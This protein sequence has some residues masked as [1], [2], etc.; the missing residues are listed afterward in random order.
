VPGALWLLYNRALTGSLTT[1]P[2][3]LWW[4]FD[5]IGFGP[6]IGGPEPGRRGF[7]FAQGLWNL[8]TDLQSLQ[9]HLFGWPFYLALALAAVPFLVGRIERWDVIFAASAFSMAAAYVFY[10]NPG[11]WYGPRYYYVIIPWL[12]L[13]S[14]RGLI[15]LYRL[16]ARRF[17]GDSGRSVAAAAF[18]VLLGAALVAY[19]VGFYIPA[20]LPTY[21]VWN[22]SSARTVQALQSTHLRQGL[23]FVAGPDSV[24]DVAF[25][26][27]SPLLSGRIV[28]ARDEG[29]RDKVLASMYP[30]KPLWRF[31]AERLRPLQGAADP[32]RGRIGGSEHLRR[33][34]PCS[35]ARDAE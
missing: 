1:T 30:G 27:N 22:E 24:Y 13:L 32:A 14:A 25:S 6:S 28:Y 23:V 8:G 12:A 5:R 26:L 15:E 7:T 2:Y 11:L 4:S 16:G 20:Q 17:H 33:A 29:S 19:D 21:R 35:C 18:P 3:T 31:L 10:F 9:A 34:L